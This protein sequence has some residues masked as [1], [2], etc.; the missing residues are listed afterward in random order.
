MG[1]SRATEIEISN[2]YSV[3]SECIKS[4]LFIGKPDFVGTFCSKASDLLS[5][6]PNIS[7]MDLDGS[8]DSIPQNMNLPLNSYYDTKNYDLVVDNGTMEHVFNV[9]QFLFN[10]SK[11]VKK[12]GFII[13]INPLSGFI[14][15]GFYQVS[16]TLYKDFYAS[17]GF[18]CISFVILGQVKQR[19]GSALNYQT[20]LRMTLESFP[21]I[22][23][24][25]LESLPFRASNGQPIKYLN[26]AIYRKN[27]ESTY[28]PPQQS[29]YS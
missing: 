28:S 24:H 22:F 12:N 26:F 10:S 7:F 17:N 5:F 4:C 15:H 23:C 2:F 27:S 9:Q 3:Y 6:C 20:V 13:H 18:S 29:I 25:S 8:K 21:Q 14:N 1:I 19:R 11:L 16:P